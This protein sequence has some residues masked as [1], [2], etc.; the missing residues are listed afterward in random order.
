MTP[1]KVQSIL[2]GIEP[3]PPQVLVAKFSNTNV[4]SFSVWIRGLAQL[5]EQKCDRIGKVVRA[6]AEI[7]D[8]SAVPVDWRQ[9][10]KLA[11]LVEEKVARMQRER[12][13]ELRHSFETSEATLESSDD[14]VPGPD[15]AELKGTED[16]CAC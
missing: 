8:E 3:P 11:S 4:Y 10:A 13:A 12:I 5:P 9:G 6:L 7:S 16:G 14:N 2:R 1:D 15:V